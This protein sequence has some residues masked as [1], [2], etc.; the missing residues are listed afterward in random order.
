M[1]PRSRK[2]SLNNETVTPSKMRF[3]SKCK[4]EILCTTC[5]NQ[6]NENKEFEANLI[7]SEREAPTQFGHMLLYYKI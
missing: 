4:D 5:N 2:K 6:N 3:C 7:F 1:L